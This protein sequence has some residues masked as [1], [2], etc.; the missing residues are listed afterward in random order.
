MLIFVPYGTKSINVLPAE[1]VQGTFK[2]KDGLIDELI[3]NRGNPMLVME[4]NDEEFES[5]VPV[6]EFLEL[7]Y[8]VL[9]GIPEITA[10]SSFLRITD[11]DKVINFTSINLSKDVDNAKFV[12]KMKESVKADK[13]LESDGDFL[14]DPED[15]GE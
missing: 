12:N 9:V 10:L 1:Y 4:T 2:N 5:L 15:V 3:A 13:S 11:Y 14:E 7:E 6:L 8:K